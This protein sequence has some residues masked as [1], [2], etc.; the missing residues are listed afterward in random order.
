M[1]KTCSERANRKSHEFKFARNSYALRFLPD[2]RL[3]RCSH[4]SIYVETE[5]LL[6][7]S[8]L[9]VNLGASARIQGGTSRKHIRAS[10]VNS[11]SCMYTFAI[12]LSK[13]SHEYISSAMYES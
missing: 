11:T 3:A 13:A 9:R 2:S 6:G 5:R 1:P 10:Q 8:S 7:W 12:A 4:V